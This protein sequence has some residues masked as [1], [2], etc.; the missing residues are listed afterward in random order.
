M[1]KGGGFSVILG[2]DDAEGEEDSE[3]EAAKA[4][5]KRFR[6]SKDDDEALE[7]FLS[8]CQYAKGEMGGGKKKS[9]EDE[10]EEE[11]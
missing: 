6:S 1:P 10:E 5:L 9:S 2:M 11:Y 3:R 4:A 7:A 8:L